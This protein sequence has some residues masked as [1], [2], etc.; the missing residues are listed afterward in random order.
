MNDILLVA[1]RELR[2]QLRARSFL[3]SVIVSAVLV[4]AVVIIPSL[5]SSDSSYDVEV[6]GDAA[7]V[8]ALTQLAQA[9]DLDVTVE[10]SD[11]EDAARAALDDGEVDVVLLDGTTVLSDGE[12]DSEL[13]ALLQQAHEA[14]AVEAGLTGLGLSPEEIEQAVGVAPLA[15]ERVDDG[16][17]YDGARQTLGF[18]LLIAMLFLLMTTTVSVAVGVIEEK[19]SRIVEILLVAVRPRDLLAGKLLAF[20][21]LGLIQ[22][23]VFG[24]AGIGSAYLVGAADDLPPGTPGVILAA[25]VGYVFGFLF[26]GVLGAALGSLTSRQEELN[27]A[28][29]PMTA[30]MMLSYFGAF[31]TQTDPESTLSRVLTLV[32]PVSSMAMPIR[33][34]SGSVS[35]GELILSVVLMLV[36]IAAIL[37]LAARIYERSVLRTG[38]RVP[39]LE[40]LRGGSSDS[41]RDEKEPV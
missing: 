34:T 6:V 13:L 1:R 38:S 40:A 23:T 37:V 29:A 28:L 7:A 20:G 36:A 31:M 8:P 33:L 21:V 26:F 25:V 17:R 15:V 35:A 10:E 39:L 24:V 16:G 19:G 41:G 3:I 18:L 27:G 4:S 5:L 22:L 11:D 14:A 9:A 32:P 30:A 12:P 2:L